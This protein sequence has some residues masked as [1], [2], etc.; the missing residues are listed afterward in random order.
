MTTTMTSSQKSSL[1][2]GCFYVAA[3]LGFGAAC[4]LTYQWAL[5]L[6]SGSWFV[7]DMSAILSWLGW[8]RAP[9]LGLP[10]VQPLI[11]RGWEA[12]NNCPIS[13]GLAFAAVAVSLL[14]LAWSAVATARDGALRNA[15]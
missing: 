14:G 12:L 3:Y 4:T 13:L 8:Q 2:T 7:Y 10:M 6:R 1:T 5:W 11:E 15:H 9:S